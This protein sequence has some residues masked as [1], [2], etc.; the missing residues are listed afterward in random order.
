MHCRSSRIVLVLALLSVVG[1]VGC[2]AE[3]MNSTAARVLF[4]KPTSEYSSGPLW[5]WNDMM[6][7]EE[8][9]STLRDLADQHVKQVWVHPRPGLMT[10]YLSD[11]WFRLWKLAL[12][13]GKRLDM[14]VWIYDENSYP[15]GFAGGHVPEVMPESR[16]RGLV[17]E[18][19]K[20][21]PKWSDDLV[22]VY[23]LA[24]SGYDNV[25][26]KVKAG[27]ALG[28]GRYL[29]AK[30][31]RAKD[32][33]WNGG[34]SYVDLMYPGVTEKFL[35]ITLEP[36][37][38]HFGKDFGKWVPG[39]F[40]DEPQLQPAGGL[41]WTEDLPKQFEARWGYSLL[42]HLPCLSQPVGEFKKVRHNYYSTLLALFGERWGKPYHDY[43]EK[44][45][46]AFTGHY[47]E[48]EW[49]NC[50]IVPDNMAMYYWHQVPS[51][52]ILL[53]QY[54]ENTHAQFGNVRACRELQSVA[55]QMGRERTLCEAYGAGGWDLR[56][57]DMKR[58][59]DWIYVLGV[60]TLNQ[61]LDFVTLRGSRKHD[62]PQSFSYH[63][64]WWEA[65]H[66]QA[67]YFARLSVA[68]TRGEQINRVLLLEPTS[69]AWMYQNDAANAARLGEIGK[70]FFDLVMDL[71]RNQVEYDI[72]CEDIIGKVGS[73]ALEGRGGKS[74]ARFRVGKRDYSLVV[75]PP[76]TENL[77]K[78]TA[79]LLL[80]YLS[81]GGKVL[82]C[83][84]APS[85]VDG[86]PNDFGKVFAGM[87]VWNQV[88]AGTLPADL[89]K[90][91]LAG[92]GFGVVRKDGDKGILFHHRRQL[93]DGDLLF[94]VN[95]S[96]DA[97]AA[98]TIHAKAKG[99]EI[100]DPQTGEIRPCMFSRT[101]DGKGVTA[102]FNLAR[103]GSLLLFLS[104]DRREPFD[105]VV[106]KKTVFNPVG[107][108]KVTRV[109][110]NV[111]PLDYVDI[112]AGGETKKGAFV[113][114]ACQ[115][116]FKKNGMA[117]NPWDCSVQFKDELITKKF[118]ADSGFEA[119][120]RFTI[121][122]DVPKSLSIV[123]ERPDLY[124]ITCNGKPIKH[125][126]KSWWLDKCFGRIDIAA[127]AKTG[128]NDVTIKA[129]P[130]TIWHELDAAYLVGD[131]GV[132]PAAKGFAIVPSAALKL[133]PWKD[134]GHPLYGAAVTY[135]E[136]FSV[137]DPS[138]RYVVSL[139]AWYGCVAK[140]AVNGKFAGYIQHQP[141]ECDVTQWVTAGVN[142]IEVTVFGT[143]KNTLGPHHNNPPLGLAGPGSFRNAPDPGPP[144]GE[145]YSVVGYGLFQPFVLTQTD[146]SP[147]A[148]R[149]VTEPLR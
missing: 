54:S 148:V 25:S 110:P 147:R 123:I 72:G 58:I 53:N 51:I 14:R 125:D 47:W 26:V 149:H 19:A 45:G 91:Q 84:D 138:G 29:V 76:L 80:A 86:K 99:V 131:F 142:T 4:A 90:A 134:Q 141:W 20:Q 93:A 95:T 119:T 112:T 63:E 68:L 105:Q 62:H 83:G 111:L 7:D 140:V 70:N 104:N 146:C 59:G 55:N 40:T 31:V 113:Y 42:D 116:A 69:S 56:F 82:C 120:Y 78:R 85:L 9:V 52:D 8:I 39:S 73:V 16:G 13:E 24:D 107:E 97:P 94:L 127:L 132:K 89:A 98:G 46:L 109:E 144:P 102:D 48:H 129:S 100:W 1:L 79:E 11:E 145:K 75:I 136:R 60:N 81:F 12:D 38:K 28:E 135:A 137:S 30:I 143:L 41:P 122:G 32:S 21:A 133:G 92:E 43:C 126:G 106:K 6:T 130:F 22:A 61:H 117:Q 3:K 57:E 36:Y 96:I 74:P 65:Y 27:E 77:D 17:L 49:P 23:R 15:S 103:C 67:D 121:E 18:E 128:E 139:P 2:Q 118:P 71:D 66:I 37:R 115:F 101:A 64:P 88:E 34:R 33:P 108:P 114:Q 5:V 35:E 50:G 44:N 10:P 87:S 124:T